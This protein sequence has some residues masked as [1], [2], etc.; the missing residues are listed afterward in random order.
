M[1]VGRSPVRRRLR[2]LALELTADPPQL[3]AVLARSD[4]KSRS[5]PRGP[6]PRD[7]VR[8]TCERCLEPRERR[9]FP[10]D[11]RSQNARFRDGAALVCTSCLRE[12]RE[13]EAVRRTLEGAVDAWATSRIATEGLV[14]APWSSAA[15]CPHCAI[16]MPQTSAYTWGC[17]YASGAGVCQGLREPHVHARCKACGYEALYDRPEGAGKRRIA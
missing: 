12:A 2:D 8:L 7:G 11:E 9:D 14:L 10:R 16:P 4:P 1:K 5:R 15:R 13:V 17:R 3:H 6:R